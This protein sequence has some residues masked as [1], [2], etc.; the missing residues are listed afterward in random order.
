MRAGNASRRLAPLVAGLLFAAHCSG[1]SNDAPPS[2]ASLVQTC[3]SIC[4]HVVAQCAA[5]PSLTA[6]CLS[7]CN[8]L[9][10][11]NLGCIAPLASYLVCLSGATSIQCQAGGQ[12]VLLSPPQCDA[13]RTSVLNCNASPGLI[14]ACIAIPGSTACVGET[15]A[16]GGATGGNTGTASGGGAVFC[17]GAP[18]GCVSPTPNPLGL[19]TYC[20]P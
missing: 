13:Q 17:V 11:A 20:C 10:L 4:A 9:A 6:E 5:P 1:S 15:P 8:D 7:A 3:D 16:P 12:Y 2:A 18:S 14:A 19:G